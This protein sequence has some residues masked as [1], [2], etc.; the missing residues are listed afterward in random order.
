ML[1]RLGIHVPVFQA[2][3]A[4]VATPALAAAVS[5]AGGLGGL[6]LGAASASA[7]RAA[8][9]DLRQRTGRPFHVNVFCHDPARR[10][11]AKEAGWLA[12]M[13]PLFHQ[14]DAQP[15]AQLAEIYASFLTDAAMQQMVLDTAPAVV[16][17]HFGL[18]PADL[19]AALQMRGV[20]ALAGVTCLAEAKQAELSGC[21]GVIAQGWEAGGHRGIFDAGGPDE[22]M[23]TLPLTALLVRETRLP[24][25][26]A[27]GI[28]DGMGIRAVLSMGAVAAQMGTAFV[29]CPESAA[30]AGYGAAL[31]MS[32]K[33]EMTRVISGRP[34]RS[35]RTAFTDWGQG[36]APEDVPDYPVAYDAGKALNG[37]AKACGVTGYGALWAGQG[38]AQARAMP[39]A[40][41]VHLLER[42]MAEV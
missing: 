12:R 4:G 23:E 27:G 10:D 42:E 25:I 40:D 16:S 15:P 26:A 32:E 41:L 9:A 31:R 17:F 1:E 14:M 28:M 7:G 24:V 36:I 34:A 38:A 33:T 30:D 8:I 35:L 22:A 6:G 2:P 19:I 29:V 5:D 11:A 13:A 3:M 37:A 20:I 18:P 39:A 21:D